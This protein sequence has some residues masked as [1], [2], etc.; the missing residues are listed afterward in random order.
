[1]TPS[2]IL[3]ETRLAI[4]EQQP[5]GIDF[6]L[7]PKVNSVTGQSVK[8]EIQGS[9]RFSAF[10]NTFDKLAQPE[11]ARYPI[12]VTLSGITIEVNPEQSFKA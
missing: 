1:M 2:G 6:T 5:D 3:I 9:I 12:D 4:P 7:S 11:K 8:L 10:H